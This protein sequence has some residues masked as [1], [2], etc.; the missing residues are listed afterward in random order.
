MIQHFFFCSYHTRATI[1]TEITS[2]QKIT[3]TRTGTAAVPPT[4][5]PAH[6]HSILKATF[7]PHKPLIV[8]CCLA[9]HF[10][11]SRSPI[12]RKACISLTVALP[13]LVRANCCTHT[14]PRAAIERQISPTRTQF[15]PALRLELVCVGAV[16]VV[17]PVHC[18]DCVGD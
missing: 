2:P 16:D 7:A 8:K 15:L 18:E 3:D 10:L 1:S 13:A 14:D 11:G 6:A 5:F 17:A 9:S 4:P 12:P